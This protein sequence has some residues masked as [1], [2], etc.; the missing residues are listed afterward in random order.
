[1]FK[2]ILSKVGW[3]DLPSSF[4]YTIGEKVDIPLQWRWELHKGQKKAD[5]SPVTFFVCGK[6]ELDSSQLASAKNA[7]QMAKT[8]KHPNILRTLDSIEI[9]GGFYIVT[10]P[11][12]PLLSDEA[13]DPSSDREP[14]VWGVYQALD[15]LSF[16][17]QSGFTHGLIGPTSIF[18]TPQGDY[19]LGAFELCRKGADAASMIAGRRRSGPSVMGLPDPPAHLA[20]ATAPTQGLDF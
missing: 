12:V 19:R 16:L 7:E 9:E 20:D 2:S 5:G 13:A 3:G 4:G 6:K 14:A 17:H 10:E 15:A 8:L 11:C 1:M 18:V